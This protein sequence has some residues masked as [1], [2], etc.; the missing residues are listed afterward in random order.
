MGPLS[1]SWP[2]E[3]TL[4]LPKQTLISENGTRCQLQIVQSIQ[5]P[6]AT[7]EVSFLCEESPMHFI[8]NVRRTSPGGTSTRV[9][10]FCRPRRSWRSS[11][12]RYWKVGVASVSY[13]SIWEPAVEGLVAFNGSKLQSG[14]GIGEPPFRGK[15]MH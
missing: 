9:H 12:W 10:H 11:S 13:P 15:V 5:A 4:W 1:L 8:D 2:P 7:S 3:E 14:G 6:H